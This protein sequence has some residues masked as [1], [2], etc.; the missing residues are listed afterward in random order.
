[1][2]KARVGEVM[3]THGWLSRRPEHFRVEV[4]Q[5]CHLRHFG[6]GEI[7]FGAGDSTAGVFGL[8]EGSIGI[9]LPNGHIATIKSPGYWTG[10]GTGFRPGGR[11]ATMVAS[12]ASHVLFLP[13]T[14]FERLIANAD[15]CRYFAILTLEHLEEAI[16]VIGNL[17]AA[18]PGA[19]VAGRLLTLMRAEPDG[20]ATFPITQG[21]LA[22]MCGLTRQT[23][24]KVV[25]RF[26]AEG[27]V[28]SSY[29]Q[30]TILDAT[31]LHHRARQFE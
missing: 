21:E 29:G 25:R 10:E 30:L 28:G 7:L 23:V 26:T 17:M 24:N 2:D 8:V 13:L 11:M 4:L 14:E 19:R 18:D 12:E 1:M 3:R 22:S 16:S 27:I 5:R 6:P 31:R 15:F 9:E 20:R